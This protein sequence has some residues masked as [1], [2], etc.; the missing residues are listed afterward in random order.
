MTDL[1]LQLST[2]NGVQA[3]TVEAFAGT[4][5]ASACEQATRVATLLGVVVRFDFNGV[6]CYARPNSDPRTLQEAWQEI[7]DTPEDK[8]RRSAMAWSAIPE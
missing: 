7:F 3:A 4:H 8:R 5:I 2:V 1:I 6:Q